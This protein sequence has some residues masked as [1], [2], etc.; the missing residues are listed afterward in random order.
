MSR[1]GLFS[2][3]GSRRVVRKQRTVYTEE[4]CYSKFPAVSMTLTEL[5]RINKLVQF[6][7]GLSGSWGPVST[8]VKRLSNRDLPKNRVLGPGFLLLYDNL[9]SRPNAGI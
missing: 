5:P 2:L 3:L 6:N 7:I 4:L 9:R 1:P 8:I